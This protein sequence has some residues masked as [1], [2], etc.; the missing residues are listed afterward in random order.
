VCSSE[1]AATSGV[2]LA[3]SPLLANRVSTFGSLDTPLG[4][5][6]PWAFTLGTAGDFGA[7]SRPLSCLS[8]DSHRVPADR[9]PTE[10]NLRYQRALSFLNLLVRSLEAEASVAWTQG[11]KT[12]HLVSQMLP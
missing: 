4:F 10:V 9:T 8:P 3:K 12:V 2:S 1:T 6:L 11:F 7:L 5:L